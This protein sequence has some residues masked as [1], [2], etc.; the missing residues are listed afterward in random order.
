MKVDGNEN[1]TN[2]NDNIYS[3]GVILNLQFSFKL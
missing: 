3:V 2:L 1:C